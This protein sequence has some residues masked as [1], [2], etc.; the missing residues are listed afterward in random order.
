[1]DATSV[2][3]RLLVVISVCT[4]R[5]V[6]IAL[7]GIT[8]SADEMSA[9][10]MTPPTTSWDK[11]QSHQDQVAPSKVGTNQQ[12]RFRFEVVRRPLA[13]AVR[14][15][16]VRSPDGRVVVKVVGQNY[17]WNIQLNRTAHNRPAG[18]PIQLDA[19]RVTA[20]AVAGDNRQ[21]ATAIGNLSEDW[22][23]VR[24]WDGLNGTELARYAISET[25]G[26]PPLG[27]VLRLTFNRDG[28]VL[29]IESTPA[30]GR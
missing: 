6:T 15:A 17:R 11:Y 2:L 5:L 10:K 23:E 24:V 14:P 8:A 21:V 9:G 25:A 26:R 30:G 1:M 4:A 13:V 27:E 19:H 22:G 28:T 20:V 16:E 29:T 3:F 18:P 12:E 7:A